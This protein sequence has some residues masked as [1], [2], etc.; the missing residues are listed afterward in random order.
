MTSCK[1]AVE[2]LEPPITVIPETLTPQTP[3]PQ[4]EPEPSQ[5]EVPPIIT[6]RPNIDG[7]MQSYLTGEWKDAEVVKRRSM[8]VMMPN[9]SKSLPQNGISNAS[10]IYE[11]P[12][13]GRGT[14]LMAFYE[15][16]DDLEMIGPIRSA[17]DYYVYEAMAYDAIFCHWGMAVPYVKDI[18]NSDRIDNISAATEDIE[19]SAWEALKRLDQ[20]EKPGIASVYRCYLLID[21]YEEAVNRLK[22]ETEYRD[23]FEQAFTFAADDMPALYPEAEDATLIYPSG[24]TGNRSGYGSHHPYFE[25][26]GEKGVYKRYQFGEP[27]IDG[28]NSEQLT[29][30]NIIF[31][32]CYGEVRDAKDYLAF[33]VHGE[34]D[35]YVFTA[36]KVIPATW[37]RESDAAANLFFDEDGN[38][39]VF[40]QG[41]TWICNIWLEYS[42]FMEWE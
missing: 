17:R 27:Q 9:D 15:D 6:E 13:E 19:K 36:G 23:T 38:E 4:P 12:V 20:S 24:S 26:D 16:Y 40:N 33:G 30:S 39:I 11:A 34:G 8:A 5:E 35:A 2:P 3:E 10:I 42:E 29:V 41:K 28:L 31:K 7:L 32:I 1:S 37:Q 25:Y 18:I 22:Y 14:R 21:G